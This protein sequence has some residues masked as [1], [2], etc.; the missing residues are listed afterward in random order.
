MRNKELRLVQ[1]YHAT[2]KLGSKIAS[3]GLKTHCKSRSE[4]R[5]LHILRNMLKSKFLLSE[6]PY[7]PKIWWSLLEAIGLKFL[8]KGALGTVEIC[9]LCGW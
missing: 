7:E 8:M 3:R 9:D 4:L 5:Y 2:V 1:E 6:Q